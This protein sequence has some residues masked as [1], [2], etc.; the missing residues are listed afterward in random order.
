MDEK[1]INNAIDAALVA[2]AYCLGAHWV[3][4]E[5]Q[6]KAL[7]I[8]WSELNAPCAAWHE[9]KGKGDFTH[10]GDHANWLHEFVRNNQYFD[11]KKY[12]DFWVNNMQNYKG[13]IDG[14]SRDTLHA[15]K[16]NPTSVLGA[17]SQ[18]LSI[19][20]RIAP[21]LLVSASKEEFLSQ[22]NAFIAFT[23]N[24]YIVL[25]AGEFLASV[26][27]EVAQGKSIAVALDSATVDPSLQDAF[28][29][30]MA[31]KGNDTFNTIRNFGPACGVEGGFEGVI[32]LL[33]TY[34]DY[35]EAMIENAKAGGDSSA[36]GMVVGMIMGASGLEIPATWKE[37]I[38][39]L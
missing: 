17:T 6:L 26:L 12:R 3:Y 23:H 38:N 34:N 10:Y 24:S 36:R 1:T 37:Q 21:L 4:D 9:G 13:Y 11:I 2:D 8:N 33:T 27:Y 16:D 25:K 32:H 30:A 14:S 15:L 35:K 5:N 20:G 7:K 18:D 29:A 28:S 31:S 39:G 22:T 19:I